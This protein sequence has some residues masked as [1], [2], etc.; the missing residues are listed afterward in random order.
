MSWHKDTMSHRL[1]FV[2][3]AADPGV[4]FS[5][6]CKRFGVSR[7]VGYKWCER[8]EQKGTLGLID[9]SRRPHSS[10]QQI[11]EEL[12]DQI[13]SLWCKEPTWGPRKLQRFLARHSG[14]AIPSVSTFAR[15]LR[16]R[17]LTDPKKSEQ[18][19]P[20]QRF[21][22][23]FPNQLWQMDFK[24][25]FSLLSGGVCHPLTVLDD[26][27]RYN[28]GLQACGDQRAATVKARLQAI[29][30]C[31]GL[32][33]QILCDNGS[34]WCGSGRHSHLSV[35]LLRLG[36]H[37]I[38]GRPHH[39]QTQ[40]KD[41]R[42]HRT[43]KED[44]I[45]RHDWRDLRHAQERFDQYRDV[46]NLDRPHDALNLDLP[47]EHYRVSERRFPAALPEL[48]YDS[49]EIVRTVKSKGEITF[50]NAFFYV[51]EAFSGYNVALRP[52]AQSDTFRVCF[53]AIT[54]GK[55]NL[56]AAKKLPRGNYQAIQPY[57]PKV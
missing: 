38:H 45:A 41:E 6:L 53:G 21:C 57:Q 35:W 51:G 13:E 22:R 14:L 25:Y 12:E 33:D 37:M 27:S 20:F 55:I 5:Q 39:P 15:V 7:R 26:C 50:Q 42:F 18:S 54:L 11:D 49:N 8:F 46:Y 4:N 34:P 40:G 1:E 30:E 29:F 32:P 17:Q 47:V 48:A 3:L 19:R 43:L 44:L 52:T 28:L 16:R 31:Y 2:S 23:A 36:I 9:Q 24:G 10:P 56:T